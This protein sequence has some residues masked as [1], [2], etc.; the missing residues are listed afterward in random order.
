MTDYTLR[1]GSRKS[2]LALEQTYII[3]RLL[4]EAYPDLKIKIVTSDTLGD[5]NLISPLQAFGGKGVFVSELEE[6]LL[7]GQ[8]DLAVHS[9]KDMP[10]K[11]ENGLCIAAAS[12]REYPG[13]VFL[14]RKDTDLAS[15][16]G[17]RFI[18]GTSS[19]RRQ[20]FFKEYWKEL[21]ESAG[22]GPAPELFFETLRGNVHTRLKKLKDGLYDGIIL[23]QAGLAR[24]GITEGHDLCFYPLDPARFIPAGGQGILAVEAKEGSPAARLCEK[25][26]M[27]EAHMC[28]DAE[29][30]V[31]AYLNAGCHEPIGVYARTEGD[32]LIL[33]AAGAVPGS[34]DPYGGSVKHVCITG[35]GKKEDIDRM[36]KKIR[37]GLGRG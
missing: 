4:K 6:A 35:S 26:D 33:Q 23:A 19:P 27:P 16:K 34:S 8:I 13:D 3:E 30:G 25:I 14:T 10:A 31:L 7:N 5:K 29:R 28:L 15:F 36:I 21:W 17:E 12:K 9:A 32:K 18:V 37:K 24:L 22:T 11:L 20:C 2:E 1:I